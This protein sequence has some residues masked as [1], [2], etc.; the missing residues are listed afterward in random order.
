MSEKSLSHWPEW[1]TLALIAATYAVWFGVT[2]FASTLT[3]WLAIPLLAVTLTLHSSLQ[4]EVVHGHPLKNRRLSEALVWAPLGLAVP[5]PRFRDQHNAQHPDPNQTEP[6]DDPETNNHDPTVWV[7]LP[8]VVGGV[9]LFKKTLI[10]RMVVGPAV[11]LVV[12]GR[13]EWRG[14]R[15]G[16]PAILRAWAL[17]AVGVAAVLAWVLG[18]STMPIWAYVA[19]V[20]LAL[21][22]LKIRT[23]LEHQAHERAMGRS[24][25]I[26]DRGP[27]AFLFLNNN[28]H[29]V[30]HACPNAPWYELPGIYAARKTEWLARNLGYRY[31]SY[32]EILRRHLL[33]RKDPVPHPLWPV[34]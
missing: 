4:H 14:A 30:H 6:N 15:A 3:P 22:V 23:F 10:G 12:F 8:A 11:G 13:D 29:A 24:V 21:S 1:P 33:R 18:V 20:Y 5:Y 16:D 28:F 9:L 32:G 25:I 27:L 31:E 26:E 7:R 17:H 19:S 34:K 2:L